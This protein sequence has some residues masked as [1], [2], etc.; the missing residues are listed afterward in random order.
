M[1]RVGPNRIGGTGMEVGRGIGRTGLGVERE[2]G[3]HG[4]FDEVITFSSVVDFGSVS[5]T[6]SSGIE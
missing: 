4:M 1:K 3:K 5:G 6:G 2:M